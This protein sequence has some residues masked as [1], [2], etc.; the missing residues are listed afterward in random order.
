TR[1]SANEVAGRGVGMD[2]VATAIDRMHGRIEMDSVAGEGTQIRVSIPLTT[3]IEHVMVVRAGGQLFALPM[4]SVVAANGQLRGDAEDAEF[5]SLAAALGV[6]SDDATATQPA[7]LMLEG[8]TGVRVDEIL[9]PDEVVVRP[10]PTTIRRHPLFNGVV[11]AGNGETVLLLNVDR[12]RQW[13]RRFG[14]QGEESAND[15]ATDDQHESSVESFRRALV[16]DD[17]MSVRKSL[18]RGLRRQGFEVV[19]AGDGIEALSCL[20][21]DD[22]DLITTDIDMPRMDGME[23]LGELS[24]SGQ[25]DTSVVVVSSRPRDEVWDRVSQNGAFAY[26]TKPASEESL[27]AVINQIDELSETENKPSSGDNHE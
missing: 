3:G 1:E 9:G 10:L 12:T 18:A 20:R 24:Q 8:Q 5:V 16:V 25:L 7:S 26:L 15:I 14:E 11:L 27:V 6:K 23:L 2:V 21:Q 4:R 17:S 19:E 22:F 13:C